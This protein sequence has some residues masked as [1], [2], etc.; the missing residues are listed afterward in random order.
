MLKAEASQSRRQSVWAQGVHISILFI[1][2]TIAFSW[3]AILNGAPLVFSDSLM[4]ATAALE[5]KIPPYF[6]VFYSW[7]IFPFHLGQ[8]L[9]PVVF[10][11]S[12]IL[13]HLLYL[14]TRCV[15]REDQ[16][17][18]YIP[19]VIVSLAILTSLPW[20]TGQLLPDVA[21]PI[22]ALGIFLLS[23]CGGRLS[24]A[25]R[26][27]LFVL[28]TLAITTHLSHIPIAIGLVVGSVVA[29]IAVL[30]ERICL[31]HWATLIGPVALAA[32]ALVTVTW[33]DSRQVSLAKDSEVFMLAKLIDEGP[34]IAY[35][36]EVCPEVGYRLCSELQSLKG[37][38]HDELKW[39]G[40]SPFRRIDSS[41]LQQEA[42]DIVRGTLATFPM[43]ILKDSINGAARQFLNF[44]TGEGL[45][46]EFAK[47]VA[48]HVA[49]YFGSDTESLLLNS[50]QGRGVLPLDQIRVLHTF[51]VIIA[52]CVC[53]GLLLYRR[54]LG[55]ITRFTLFIGWALIVSAVVTGSL[56]G[57]YDRYLARVIWLICF[58]AILC[59]GGHLRPGTAKIPTSSSRLRP[60]GLG[61]KENTEL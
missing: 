52:L 29:K 19:W 27:Y 38:S 31:S 42:H 59:L 3:V 56:S 30:R 23:F 16:A 51:A 32:S 34:A 10:V 36:S 26:I 14:T 13:T 35:L 57:P 43:Q 48:N 53:V 8:N 47:M 2:G 60:P 28:T 15:L 24:R 17:L 41:T 54:G 20:L 55:Q 46:P 39:H 49:Q 33:I 50:Q 12:A 44:Q 25:E 45:S 61:Q 11:Q 6:S 18:R 21:S 5:G 58:A 9:W 4:Y 40:W 7:L 37:L 22:V 1:F